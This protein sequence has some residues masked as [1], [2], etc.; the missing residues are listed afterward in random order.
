MTIN[1]I[2][3]IDDSGLDDSGLDG[4]Y[5]WFCREAIKR[6]CD[7]QGFG[8][9]TPDDARADATAAGHPIEDPDRAP[10]RFDGI[11]GL[12]WYAESRKVR[13]ADLKI[14]DWLDSLDRR[15][16]RKIVGLWLG[17]APDADD[18]TDWVPGIHADAKYRTAI[19]AGGDGETVRA[20][21]EYDVVNP[22]SQVAPD[23]ST[24]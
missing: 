4:T 10:G 12:V 20:D 2:A 6:R 7:G 24:L 21:V 19:F 9:A 13:G 18:D 14:G 3:V 1:H 23:G 5:S 17:V 8:F 16:A 15:G 22:E 11:P